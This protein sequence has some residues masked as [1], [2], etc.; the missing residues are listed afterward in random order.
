MFSD[1]TSDNMRTR[2]DDYNILLPVINLPA[3]SYFPGIQLIQA[4]NSLPITIKS[5]PKIS[6]FQKELKSHLTSSYETECLLL[7]CQSCDPTV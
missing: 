2:D 3:L 7:N 5:E 1:V 4:W 6:T